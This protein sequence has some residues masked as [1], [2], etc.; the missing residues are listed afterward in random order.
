MQKGKE[1]LVLLGLQEREVGC[2]E[3]AAETSTFHYN[4]VMNA[5]STSSLWQTALGLLMPG[6]E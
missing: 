3:G 2:F 1:V 4:A 5:C 6:N